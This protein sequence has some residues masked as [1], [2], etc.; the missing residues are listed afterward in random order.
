MT[1]K[2]RTRISLSL[3]TALLERILAFAAK[4]DLAKSAALEAAL[5]SFL[6][7]D[8]EPR[9]EAPLARRL[10]RL[11]LHIARLDEDITILG[12][13]VALFVRFWLSATP[14]LTASAQASAHA[15]GAGRYDAFLQALGRRLAQG[16]GFLR[17]VSYDANS[18][19]DSQSLEA[20]PNEPPP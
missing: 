13:A 6:D 14:A 17:E 1:I 5:A 4:H 19:V 20:I 18:R 9:Q 11:S 12:E 16:D 15:K 10:D 3:D 8:E 2:A 7:N